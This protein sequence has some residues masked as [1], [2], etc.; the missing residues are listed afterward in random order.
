MSDLEAGSC[1]LKSNSTLGAIV[2]GSLVAYL[3]LVGICSIEHR[4]AAIVVLII[5]LGLFACWYATTMLARWKR[6]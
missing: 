3:F 4:Q 6:R 1:E 2:A 5:M